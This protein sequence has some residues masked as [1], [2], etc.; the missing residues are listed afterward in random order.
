MI[1]GTEMTVTVDGKKVW[2]GDAGPAA[3][4]LNGPVGI[5]SDNVRLTLELKAGQVNGPH[6]QFLAACVSGP[7][8]SD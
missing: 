1:R 4:D 5:R 8:V 2:E 7:G 6:P 3:A